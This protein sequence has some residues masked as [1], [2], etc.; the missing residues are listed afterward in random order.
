MSATMEE[1]IKRSH[2]YKVYTL[3]F[4]SRLVMFMLSLFVFHIIIVSYEIFF[5]LYCKVK[6]DERMLPEQNPA[7]FELMKGT[8]QINVFKM[9]AK[10]SL[11]W[12]IRRAQ[13]IFSKLID[14]ILI[15]VFFSHKIRQGI[16]KYTNR[17]KGL[18]QIR[19]SHMPVKDAN[20]ICLIFLAMGIKSVI[21]EWITKSRSDVTDLLVGTLIQLVKYLIFCPIFIWLFSSVYNKTRNGLIFASYI[22]IV[23]LI[24]VANCTTIISEPLDGLE[25]IPAK[26]LGPELYRELVRMNLDEKIFWDQA[27]EGENAALVR[28]GAARYIIVMG[29]LLKYG[30]KEFAS[31]IA[32]EVGHADDSSTE[33]KLLATVIGLGLSCGLM[34]AILRIITPKFEQHDVPRFSVVLFLLL[35]NIHIFSG[36]TNMFYNNLSILSEVNADLYAKNLGFGETLAS[37]LYKLVVDSGNL[38]FH[39]TIYTYY[40]Q[41]HPVVAARIAYLNK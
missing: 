14:Y 2:S 1:R 28:T 29:N 26:E 16:M 20:F 24:L 37:G 18:V 35:A 11:K 19:S 6:L 7:L 17:Y 23:V 4:R 31:F 21:G 32:H 9:Q 5:L 36:L 41:D 12:A 33:K 25:K 30:Q 38:L 13:G 10:L 15:I 3:Y 8:R 22:A 40:A 39:S 34:V 27:A